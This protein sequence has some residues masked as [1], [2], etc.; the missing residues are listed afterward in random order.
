L[1]LVVASRG[2]AG[3]GLATADRG[4]AGAGQDVRPR[5][6][7]V[8]AADNAP[9]AQ[10]LTFVIRAALATELAGSVCVEIGL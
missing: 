3:G 9:A 7:L 8:L 2:R 6:D 1:R 5:V 10:C 4:N